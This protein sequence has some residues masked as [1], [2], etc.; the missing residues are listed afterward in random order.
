MSFF[1]SLFENKDKKLLRELI[2]YNAQ[3]IEKETFGTQFGNQPLLGFAFRYN[4]GKM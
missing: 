4:N 3:I 2:E 1:N